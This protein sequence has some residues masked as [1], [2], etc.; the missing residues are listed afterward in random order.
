MERKT[1]IERLAG[2]LVLATAVWLFAFATCGCMSP[3]RTDALVETFASSAVDTAMDRLPGV[4]DGVIDKLMERLPGATPLNPP[5]A[6]GEAGATPGRAQPGEGGATPGTTGGGVSDGNRWME[7]VEY[8][9]LAA[10]YL[11]RKKWIPMGKR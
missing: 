2:L 1:K 11:A 5:L 7:W 4:I 8:A 3:Q 10:L 9:V 6:R